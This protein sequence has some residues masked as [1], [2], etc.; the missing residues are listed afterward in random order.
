MI[1]YCALNGMITKESD[2][3]QKPQIIEQLTI[4]EFCAEINISRDTFYNWKKK[5]PDFA[6][7]VRSRR[8]ELFSLTRESAVYNRLYLIGMT[9]TSGAAV[10]ALEVLA[11]HFAELTLPVQ[12]QTI[13]IHGSA[14]ELLKAARD[15]GIIEGEVVDGSAT[16][17]SAPDTAANGGDAGTLPVSP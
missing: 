4:S 17:G 2:D 13:K 11:G 6:A 10:R 16:P 3:P 5:I 14:S 7:R 9:G 15:D 1:S 12:R 8:I